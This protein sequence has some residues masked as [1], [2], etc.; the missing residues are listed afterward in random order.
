MFMEKTGYGLA[1]VTLIK[2]NTSMFMEKTSTMRLS[3]SRSQKTPPCSWRRLQRIARGHRPA[4][5]TCKFMEK[6]CGSLDRCAKFEKHLH[7]HGEDLRVRAHV[8][9]HV[10]TPPCSWRRPWAESQSLPVFGNTSM[11][12]EKTLRRLSRGG[13]ARNTS[14]FMEKTLNFDNPTHAEQNIVVC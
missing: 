6:T 14:M 12:M 9:K 10:E 3:A 4:R 1:L 13:R 5:N 2:R 8:R 11:F 7:V